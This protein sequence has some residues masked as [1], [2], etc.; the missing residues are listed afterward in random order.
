[1]ATYGHEGGYG[2]NEDQRGGHHPRPLTMA[3]AE[4][5]LAKVTPREASEEEVERIVERVTGTR[6]CDFTWAELCRIEAALKNDRDQCV[7]LREGHP[8]IAD[9][10]ERHLAEIGSALAK[11]E[12]ALA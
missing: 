6:V 10:M 1:M 11:V 5:A 2:F 7:R 8:D 9:I 3:E 4:E 12:K